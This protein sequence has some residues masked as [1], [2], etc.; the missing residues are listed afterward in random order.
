MKIF[1]LFFCTL[2]ICKIAC[3]PNSKRLSKEVC[4]YSES[5]KSQIYSCIEKEIPDYF[6]NKI[7]SFIRCLGKNSLL[8]IINMI[9]ESN[10]PEE[11]KAHCPRCFSILNLNNEVEHETAADYVAKCM[12]DDE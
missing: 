7:K 4:D 9:C 6:R 3:R 11:L 2:L 8:E 12:F 1:I 5:R 10:K